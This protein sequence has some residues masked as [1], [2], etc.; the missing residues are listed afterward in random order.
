MS[1]TGR[2]ER[3]YR[4]AQ[5]EGIPRSATGGRKAMF[6]ICAAQN[7]GREYRSAKRE[8]TSVTA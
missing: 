6:A 5:R 2:P 1:A 3:D 8:S 7:D 4:N